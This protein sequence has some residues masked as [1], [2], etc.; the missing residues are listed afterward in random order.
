MR[1]S[2]RRQRTGPQWHRCKY[3][4]ALHSDLDGA[5]FTAEI[6][7]SWHCSSVLFPSSKI[8]SIVRIGIRARAEQ[9]TSDKSVCDIDAARDAVLAEI[10]EFRIRHSGDLLIEVQTRV[11]LNADTNSLRLAD[12][13]LLQRRQQKL[14]QED[15]RER[16]LFLR[17]EVMAE[18]AMGR[19][20]WMLQKPDLISAVGEKI[21]TETMQTATNRD[22]DIRQNDIVEIIAEFAHW[23]D[24]DDGRAKLA[25]NMLDRLL[26][27]FEQEELRSRFRSLH[28][29]ASSN[30]E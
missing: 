14:S 29:Q 28:P 18:P 23:L 25:L 22:V 20:W 19:I 4:T 15:E 11:K 10:A 7:A 1:N 9:V 12:Q 21:F 30:G 24:S 17:N 8:E 16:L 6:N 3:T 13:R 2:S 5:L 27:T 26:D